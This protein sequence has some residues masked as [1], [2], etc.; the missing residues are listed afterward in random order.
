MENV[1]IRV[2]EQNRS[3]INKFGT[4]FGTGVFTP[5]K[6]GVILDFNSRRQN[7]S[8]HDL[9]VTRNINRFKLGIVNITGINYAQ[10]ADGEDI[11]KISGVDPSGKEVTINC[12]VTNPTFT[13]EPTTESLREALESGKTAFFKSGRKMKDEINGLN[14]KELERVTKLIAELTS[15]QDNLKATIKSNDEKV[16]TYYNQLDNKDKTENVHIHM[17]VEE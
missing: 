13:K 8:S 11:V 17:T 14:Y 16:D 6:E 1:N 9:F 10:D 2:I 3:Q 7:M 5:S 4:V 12:E 15:I